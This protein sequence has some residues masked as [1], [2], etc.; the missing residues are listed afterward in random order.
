MVKKKKSFWNS[1]RNN[2]ALFIGVILLLSALF[3]MLHRDFPFFK[4]QFNQDIHVCEEQRCIRCDANFVWQDSCKQF[5]DKSPQ[6]LEIDYCNKVPQDLRRCFVTQHQKGHA[7]FNKETGETIAVIDVPYIARPRNYCDDNP[8]DNESCFCEEY[9]NEEGF[10]VIYVDVN[11]KTIF[12]KYLVCPY[13]KVCNIPYHIVD[14]K[15]TTYDYVFPIYIN[16]VNLSGSCIQAHPKT[17]CEKGNP[18][19]VEE[20]IYAEEWKYVYIKEIDDEVLIN[21][22]NLN[23]SQTTCREKTDEEIENEKSKETIRMQ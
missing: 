21:V 10:E 16:M 13:D 19:F 14:Y 4:K 20:T 22:P 17:E 11:N 7:K 5:R 9:K 23:K 2:I 6:E 1:K 8:N 15:G 18:D 3:S 12:T